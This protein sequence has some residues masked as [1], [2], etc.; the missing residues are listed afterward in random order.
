MINPS[1]ICPDSLPSVAIDDRKKLPET[2]CV[3]F[4][5]D[6]NNVIQYIGRS[7]NPRQRWA[8]HHRTPQLVELGGVR[9]SYLEISNSEL[10]PEIEKA[11]IDW[12]T[13]SLNS[14]RG[15]TSE[16]GR[17]PPR[18]TLIRNADRQALFEEIWQEYPRLRGDTAR[19][20]H[21]ALEMMADSAP[22]HRTEPDRTGQNIAPR[23]P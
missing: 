16:D 12:F 22:R 10:L 19:T 8:R 21:L 2:P 20:M 3:Y 5:I 1:E 6:S 9:I 4:A 15:R 13:P 23:H 17:L 11:L 7:V 18:Y 14:Q